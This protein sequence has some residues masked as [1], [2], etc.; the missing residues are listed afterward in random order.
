MRTNRE[1]RASKVSQLFLCLTVNPRVCHKHKWMMHDMHG[2]NTDR[3]RSFIHTRDTQALEVC[4]TKIC[5]ITLIILYFV[6][7][8][9][10]KG[11]TTDLILATLWPSNPKMETSGGR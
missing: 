11:T 7:S 4:F 10:S 1:T 2:A 5:H 9:Y 8:L 3:I 6:I